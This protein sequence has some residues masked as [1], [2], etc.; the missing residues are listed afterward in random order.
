MKWVYR[1]ILPILLLLSAEAKS[2]AYTYHPFPDSNAVWEQ[3]QVIYP[4]GSYT[5]LPKHY[6]YNGDTVIDNTSYHKLFYFRYGINAFHGL[7][8][9]DTLK[10]TFFR[11]NNSDDSIEH[12]IYD[13]SLMP[14]DTLFDLIG[15]ICSINPIYSDFHTIIDSKDTITLLDGSIRNKFNVR[16]F[17][18]GQLHYSSAWIEG[19][20][21]LIGPTTIFMGYY[22]FNA[23]LCQFKYGNAIVYQNTF[24]QCNYFSST[25]NLEEGNKIQITPNPSTTSFT[26]QLSSPPT[27]QTYFLLYDALGRQV[28]REEIIST[29]T[30]INR[31]NLPNGISFW[32]LQA[33]N[34]ILGRGKVVME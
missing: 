21:C 9:S 14:G 1:F 8:R 31:D 6:Y 15:H 10:R 29:T 22:G 3:W 27:T 24:A 7:I 28:K 25:D 13:F 18:C 2:Q 11:W 23:T 30:T 33:G 20:G 26:L 34:E 16:I 19:I 12:L 17:Y 32:Q 5:P 4:M